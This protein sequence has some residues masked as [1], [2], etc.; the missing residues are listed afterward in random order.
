VVE[1]VGKRTGEAP[2]LPLVREGRTLRKR[3][4]RAGQVRSDVDA[5]ANANLQYAV[6]QVTA[7]VDLAIPV[8][9]ER[10][11]EHDDR[12]PVGIAAEDVE[13]A[14]ARLS[15]D[16][17]EDAVAGEEEVQPEGSRQERRSQT[18]GLDECRRGETELALAI[19]LE[20]RREKRRER[21]AGDGVRE[22]EAVAE[23]GGDG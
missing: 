19:E 22:H 1:R 12:T 5:R 3:R 13:A 16:A 11:S 6:G 21:L 15:G 7:R 2:S 18:L 20:R 4:R 8:V 10:V 9:G 23:V 14:E 17:D